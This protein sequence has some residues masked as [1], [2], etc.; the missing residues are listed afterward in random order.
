M[1]Y[2]GPWNHIFQQKI[3]YV[4][5]QERRNEN[6][7]IILLWRNIKFWKETKENIF[8]IMEYGKKN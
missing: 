3:Y 7:Y 8:K 6:N 5:S 2:F 4:Y 1:I